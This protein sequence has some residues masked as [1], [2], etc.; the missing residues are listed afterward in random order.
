MGS[1]FGLIQNRS[2]FT[3]YYVLHEDNL[4]PFQKIIESGTLMSPEKIKDFVL[5][6]EEHETYVLKDRQ[7]TYT[8]L[9]KVNF[10]KVHF[11]TIINEKGEHIKTINVKSY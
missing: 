8:G 11:L 10:K 1:G 2:G 5:L 9:K 3:V 6:I 4:S 7:I